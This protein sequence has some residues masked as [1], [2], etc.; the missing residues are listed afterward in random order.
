MRIYRLTLF[1][2][3]LASVSAYAQTP[4]AAPDK[5]P[6]KSYEDASRWTEVDDLDGRFRIHTP[7]P[8]SHKADTL[9]TAVGDQVFHTYFFK[10]PDLQRAENLIYVLSY[11]DY[12]PGALHQDSTELV[13]ELLLSTQESAAE[14]LRGEVIYATERAVEGFPGRLWRIDYKDGEASAR[15]LAFVAGGRYFELKTFALT[16]RGLGDASDKFFRSFRYL[17]SGNETP[18][19][20]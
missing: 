10:V 15:T 20:H 8:L 4:M 13:E 19:K 17:G 16:G 2:F 5:E 18:Q 14:A 6:V 12:P 1:L 7:G 11:V 3:F 9:T